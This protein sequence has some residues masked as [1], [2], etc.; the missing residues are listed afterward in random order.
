MRWRTTFSATRA[1]WRRSVAACPRETYIPPR[2]ATGVTPVLLL[3][4]LAAGRVVA[5][6]DAFEVSNGRL[7]IGL[8]REHGDLV[9]LTD[10]HTG[11]NFAGPASTTTNAGLW[12]LSLLPA[13]K[14]VSPADAKSFHSRPI[15][16]KEPALRLTWEQFGV[17]AAPARR[18]EVVV[19]LERGQS[20][21]RWELAVSG[22]GGLGVGQV[23]FP[24]IVNIPRQENERLAV[25]VWMGEQLAEPRRFFA[26][27]GKGAKRQQWGYPGILSMRS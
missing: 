25:P 24:R 14:I 20:M 5:A 12:E 23:R 9:R 1:A 13:E 8:G 15:R 3:A 21:S 16:G 4:L 22:L 27:E 7:D 17:V 2:R 19:R 26:G 18:G 6:R 11:Q 10:A